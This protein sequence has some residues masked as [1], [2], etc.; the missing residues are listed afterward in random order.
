LIVKD[1]WFLLLNEAKIKKLM[2]PSQTC[3]H[4]QFVLEIQSDL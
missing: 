4:L 3:S 2:T 1:K